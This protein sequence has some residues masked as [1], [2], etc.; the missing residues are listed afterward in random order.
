VHIV[1]SGCI[2]G[3][4]QTVAGEDSF[5]IVN[6]NIVRALHRIGADVRLDAWEVWEWNPSYREKF[7]GFDLLLALSQREKDFSDAVT[8]RHS[9]PVCNPYYDARLSW[10]TI[11]GRV[12]IGFFIWESE[13]MPRPWV[14]AAADVDMIIAISPF[15]ASRIEQELRSYGVPTPVQ[16]IP[17][18]VDRRLFHPAFP[19]R[20]LDVTRSFRF[21]YVGGWQIRKGTDILLEA[22]LGEFSDADDVT[23][24]VQSRGEEN[25]VWTAALPPHAPHILIVRDSIPEMEMGGVYTACHCLVH[26]TRLEG[27]GM[28]MLE[29][30]A[31][32]VPVLC[33]DVGGQRVFADERNAILLPTYEEQYQFPFDL[34]GTAYHVEVAVLRQAMREVFQGRY[35]SKR[36]EEGLRTA[37]A[38]SWERCAK[39]IVEC[40]ESL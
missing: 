28:T 17:L 23:L 29:A 37:E 25:P 27:F 36:I 39:Q 40:V 14:D 22:Y 30:M 6:R 7:L 8:I 20:I 31:C 38:F 26:P 13:H 1:W 4:V 3:G 15:S 21:L 12:R 10:N 33:S 34:R 11:K 24:V 19:P 5:S 35:G 32:G 18:G 16:A 2:W 9:W